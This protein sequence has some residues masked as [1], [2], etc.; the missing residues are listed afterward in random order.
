MDGASACLTLSGKGQCPNQKSS[1]LTLGCFCV[2]MQ[3]RWPKS[4]P[5]KGVHVTPEGETTK[6]T[7]KGGGELVRIL[8]FLTH[9]QLL[10][11]FLAKNRVIGFPCKNYSHIVHTDV[12]SDHKSKI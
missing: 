8:R 5:R 7:V 12:L 9:G 6:E 4:D 3:K 10:K 11:S 1:S 2:K